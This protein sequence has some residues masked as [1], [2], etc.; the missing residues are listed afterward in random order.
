MNRKHW[1]ALTLILL[2]F[3]LILFPKL[4]LDAATSGLLLW[5]NKVLPSLLPFVILINILSRLDLLAQLSHKLSFLTQI[6]WRL[7]GASL[8]AYL[9]GFLA[10]YPMGAKMVRSLYNS[11]QLSAQEA[12][13]TLCF[14]NNCGPLFIVG[15]VGTSMLTNTSTGYFLLFIHFIST[16]CLVFIISAYPPLPASHLS[17]Q[18][19]DT[20]E[21]SF[22][23]LFNEAVS[24]AMDTIV[25]VG[26]Y[27]I[28]FSVLTSLLLHSPFTQC[29]QKLCIVFHIDAAPIIRLSVGFL[30]L[31]N[32][33]AYLSKLP[34]SPITLALIAA[35]LGFGGLCVYFQTL[36]VLG[37]DSF[38]AKGYFRFKLF[39][40]L[41]SFLL[42]LTL[43]PFWK[44][45]TL[46][47]FIHFSLKW[48][49]L[50]VSILFFSYFFI[51]FSKRSNTY[52]ASKKADIH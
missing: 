42:V 45:Y 49:V 20:P 14:C 26:G 52:K 6:L 43:Y 16:L 12:S 33:C 10:G 4:C 40:G 39:Q 21:P 19:N 17:A 37:S 46:K 38:L 51:Y 28:F 5:F 48:P 15:T 13:R 32:G 25:C 44:L 31:S 41:I 7:P 24:N 2:T 29:L 22:S 36:Y 1:L 50:L 11:R 47:T 23:L 35:V 30:E 3:T 9:M 27:I 18:K 8:L 34:C